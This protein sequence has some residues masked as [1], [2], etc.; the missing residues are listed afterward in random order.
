MEFERKKA[1]Q[2]AL[3]D[4]RSFA[5]KDE[6]T[7]QA[8]NEA[9]NEVVS[10]S[11]QDAAEEGKGRTDGRIHL[12]ERAFEAM[13]Y[14]KICEAFHEKRRNVY[15]GKFIS[16]TPDGK[17]AFYQLAQGVS[18]ALHVSM[19]SLCRLYSFQDINLPRE[20]TVVIAGIDE[21]GYL[22]LSAKPAFGD[23]E[24]SVNRLGL[25]DGMIVEGI[26]AHIMPEGAAA[27]ML[28]PNVSVL[29]TACC[30]VYPGDRVK[31]RVRRIDW[32]QHRIKVQMLEK[33]SRSNDS[34]DYAA[35]NIPVEQLGEYIELTQF[36]ERIRLK[37]P[38]PET[39]R[40]SGEK[41][42]EL[43]FSVNAVR[44]PFSTYANERVVREVR[45]PSRVQDIYFEA[46][47]GYLGERHI[48]VANAVE[49]LKYASAWQLRRYLYLKDGTLL[50]EREIKGIVD[51]LVKHDVIGVLRFQS[52]EGNL[53][54]R[55]LHPSLNFRAFSGR[56]PR[57]F[58]AKDF[59]ESDASHIKMRLASNQLLIGLWRS[60]PQAQEVDT[61]SFLRD[62]EGNVHIRPRHSLLIDGTRCYLE[63][64]RKNWTEQMLDKLRRYE[65]FLSYRKENAAVYLVV[66]DRETAAQIV[67]R[68]SE[69]KLSFAV[70]VTDD[71][72]CLPEPELTMVPVCE[73]T[74]EAQEHMPPAKGLFQ[75]FKKTPL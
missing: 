21:R 3:K 51:R 64:V 26:V 38:Q 8:A 42:E 2:T 32:E 65:N 53:L 30:R 74:E 7:V 37:R 14:Q 27:V 4:G 34:F 62:D 35:W 43:D 66:E 40:A 39:E 58:G 36:E 54:T 49:A 70:Y 9:E 28:A 72:H 16:T 63:A 20:L 24:Y 45:R 15:S 59:M 29:A 33:L 69:M 23:F 48:K 56:N 12:S 22:N 6:E 31:L 17:L 75:R 25:T 47:M 5:V 57:N 61:H 18:G 19:F 44:S 10:E 1:L 50:S 68:I 73:E 41:V 52:D 55:V 46:R 67:Q 71:I 13:E 11:K 60:S